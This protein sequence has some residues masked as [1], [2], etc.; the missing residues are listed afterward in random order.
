MS[1]QLV[2]VTG[3]GTG[4]GLGI[5]GALVEAGNRALIVGR[6]ASV[7]ETAALS[8]GARASWMVHDLDRIDEAHALVAAC[9]AEHGPIS[10]LVNNAGR[11]F[12]APTATHSLAE[13][14]G[15]MTTNV[16]AVFA[17]TQA[18]AARM[19]ERRAGSIVMI[20]SMTAQVGLPEVAA[21][22]A[23]KAALLGLART[24]AVEWSRAGLR[25]NVVCPGFVETDIFNRVAAADPGRIAKVMARIPAGRAGTTAEIGEMVTFLCSDRS[26][27]VTG[28]VIN[29]DG[30]YSIGF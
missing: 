16:T 18:V 20:S 12:K 21:Y 23:S 9:E 7:L 26:R 25:V 17:L 30:G 28:A 8:L 2:L 11:H 10:A 27:Y 5:A 29:V 4:I 15:V 3:G 22:A 1:E 19:L 13:F 24:C 6:R 14:V